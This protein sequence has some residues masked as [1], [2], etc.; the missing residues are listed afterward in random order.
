MKTC[1]K[2]DQTLA[3]NQ[4]YGRHTSC[5]SC[6]IRE[7]VERKRAKRISQGWV[8]YITIINSHKNCKTCKESLPLDRYR[9][10]KSGTLFASCKFCLNEKDK[11]YVDTDRKRLKARE[12]YWKNKDNIDARR[13]TEKYKT[14][15]RERAHKCYIKYK[16]T[17]IKKIWEDKNREQLSDSY[18]KYVLVKGTDLSARDVPE[19]L[20]KLKKQQLILTRKLRNHE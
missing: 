16:T 3:L 1:T 8:D 9:Q 18:V 7:S 15:Q 12:N 13:A 20:V 14:E 17:G 4:Y 19:S 2:C 11:S 5:K 6:Q 10:H